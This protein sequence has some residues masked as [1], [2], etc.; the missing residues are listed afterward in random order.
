M[1]VNLLK[2]LYK[3][4]SL[5][6]NINRQSGQWNAAEHRAIYL[7]TAWLLNLSV[8][9]RLNKLYLPGP[10]QQT[11]SS[12]LQALRVASA[13]RLIT[14]NRR[15]WELLL[16]RRYTLKWGMW[17]NWLNL[18]YSTNYKSLHSR[19]QRPL[20]HKHLALAIIIPCSAGIVSKQLD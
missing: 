7:I 16:K 11:N 18:R 5:L 3:H 13:S 14:Y 12:N 9:P 6:A 10:H 1:S 17:P 15:L 19:S 20:Y 2:G 8:E 4:R